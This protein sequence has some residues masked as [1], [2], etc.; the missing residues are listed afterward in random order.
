MCVASGQQSVQLIRGRILWPTAPSVQHHR[1]HLL[2]QQAQRP[3]PLLHSL[4]FPCTLSTAHMHTHTSKTEAVLTSSKS[5]RSVRS[6]SPWNLPRQSAPLRAKKVTGTG[7]CL[8]QAPAGC[9]QDKVRASVPR[10]AV[11]AEDLTL[12]YMQCARFRQTAQQ[13]A[14]SGQLLR[15]SSSER[16]LQDMCTMYGS[17]PARAR[18]TSVLPVPGTPWNRMPLQREWAAQGTMGCVEQ[19]CKSSMFGTA[20]MG[21]GLP[22]ASGQGKPTSVC[23]LL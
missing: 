5:R 21:G 23:D 22:E 19:P 20:P 12:C 9:G 3:S 6:A 11:S 14:P 16:K 17:S 2:K 8:A 10:S 1:A 7:E 15:C 13:P 18:A 4:G